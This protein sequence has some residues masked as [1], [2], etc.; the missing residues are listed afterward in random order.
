[1]R[2]DPV[3]VRCLVVEIGKHWTAKLTKYRHVSCREWSVSQNSIIWSPFA[4]HQPTNQPAAKWRSWVE[5]HE[6]N[7]TGTTYVVGQ[8]MPGL[9]TPPH[10][11]V[12]PASGTIVL[13]IYVGSVQLIDS[14]R[15]CDAG[16]RKP[17]VPF[18]VGGP[19]QLGTAFTATHTLRWVCF[20]ALIVLVGIYWIC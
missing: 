19:G 4:A 2:A 15:Y 16:N 11:A 8:I 18:P 7:F 5:H 1:M 20:V 12:T 9:H 17:E 10:A 14:R 13:G 3:T 6:C